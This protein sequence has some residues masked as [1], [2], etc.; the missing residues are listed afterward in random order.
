MKPLNVDVDIIL[1]AMTGRLC[2]TFLLQSKGA[3]SRVAIDL[4]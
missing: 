4:T 1:K 2:H 3:G